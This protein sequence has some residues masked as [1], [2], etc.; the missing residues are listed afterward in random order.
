MQVDLSR[1]GLVD[2]LDEKPVSMSGVGRESI[3]MSRDKPVAVHHFSMD[4]YQ[5]LTETDC[6]YNLIV[7]M[8]D[9]FGAMS[10][11]EILRKL[12]K[13]YPRDENDPG[14]GWEIGSVTGRVNELLKV[15]RLK[16]IGKT[17]DGMTGKEVRL[18]DTS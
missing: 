10:N 11:H 1:F 15:G 8:L 5:E 13:N 17:V 2:P 3:I 6:T 7:F 9:T 4:A 18:V 12:R 16:T 14:M